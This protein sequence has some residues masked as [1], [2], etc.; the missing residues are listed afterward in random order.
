MPG[1]G[2]TGTD[3]GGVAKAALPWVTGILSTAGDLISNNAN[4][5]EAER[6]RQFQERMSSTAV[7]RSVADYKAAGLNPALAYERSESSPSGSTANSVNPLSGAISSA[8]QAA[9]VRQAMELARQQNDADLRVKGSV[10][11]TNTANA[12]LTHQQANSVFQQMVRD[13]QIWE[14]FTKKAQPYQL[15]TAKADAL[16]RELG[17]PSAEY[18]S[19]KGGVKRDLLRGGI[20]NADSFKRIMLD[21]LLNPL[22]H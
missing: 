7:Q 21:A 11:Q 9:Q 14:E 15:R 4:R 6:N 5:A 22:G 20:S 1:E 3:W 8:T 16:L 13:N 18:E 12:E 10:V 2:S 19:T 17:I